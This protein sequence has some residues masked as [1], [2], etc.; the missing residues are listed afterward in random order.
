MENLLEQD[1]KAL[2]LSHDIKKLVWKLSLP[3]IA[4]M[5][6]FGLN[7]VSD[8]IFVGQ[9]IG[10]AAL[11]GVALAGPLTAIVL[12]FGYWIG[13]GAANVL[14]IALGADDKKTQQGILAN[15]AILTLAMTLLFALPIYL[16]AEPLIKMM[17]GKGEILA[18][19]V[20]YFKTTVLGAVFWIYGM[21]LNLIIRGE[22]KMRKSAMMVV[23]GL[24]VNITLTPFFII[25]L[26]TGV[27]GA[28]WATNVGMLVFSMD[29]ILYFK[30]GKASFIAN[31][32]S[33]KYDK[34]IA[35]KI[36]RNGFPGF[37][38]NIMALVQ[39]MV[40]FNVVIKIGNEKDVA[41]FAAA[42]VIYLFLMTHAC[43]SACCRNQLR[44]KTIRQNKK[45][46]LFFYIQWFVIDYSVL[47]IHHAFP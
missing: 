36:I 6:L 37:I 44:G 18:Q 43:F 46:I 31:I 23:Y 21:S 19:G 33:F 9:L 47:G 8:S 22:G 27:E 41:F 10:Q 30:N 16:A 45:R 20:I 4:S 24:V 40:V 12:G 2:I 11:S 14:S 42:N 26:G 34:E 39:A 3:S 15:T 17:G 29:G 28:A 38:F 13:T 32:G 7:T 5:V 35:K 25:I 1:Q